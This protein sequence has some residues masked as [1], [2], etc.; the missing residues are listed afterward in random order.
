MPE[1]FLHFGLG[2]GSFKPLVVRERF[3][4]VIGDEVVGKRGRIAELFVAPQ[5]E[6]VTLM[7]AVGELVFGGSFV[8]CKGCPLNGE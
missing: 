5:G 8:C 2:E 4:P 3:S 6:E 7:D 1:I